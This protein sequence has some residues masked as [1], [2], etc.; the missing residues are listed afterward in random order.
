MTG[1]YEGNSRRLRAVVQHL[2]IKFAERMHRRGHIYYIQ[3]EDTAETPEPQEK[4][5]PFPLS[6]K[7]AVTRVV[8]ILKRSRGR[9]I[10]GTFNPMLISQLFWEQSEGW[11][12]IARGHVEAVAPAYK[13]FL[14]DVLDHVAAPELKTRLLSMTVLPA[15]GAALNA[16]LKEL[17]S[18]ESDIPS[19]TTTILRT[20][21][22]RP[23]KN[24]SQEG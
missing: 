11:G 18:I 24:G 13:N 15:L 16:A 2:N 17:Q 19:R 8:Q 20:L 5:A 23:S 3:E 6:R 10:P 21:C 22:R 14:L 1:N 7:A 12:D 9:E 4:S